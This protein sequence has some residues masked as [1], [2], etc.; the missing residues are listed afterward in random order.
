MAYHIVCLSRP[1]WSL[2][3]Y[4]IE[5]TD[6]PTGLCATIS[7][8]DPMIKSAVIERSDPISGDPADTKAFVDSELK[9]YEFCVHESYYIVRF[10]KICEVFDDLLKMLSRSREEKSARAE[11][12]PPRYIQSEPVVPQP[13]A[14]PAPVHPVP[15]VPRTTDNEIS[16]SKRGPRPLSM[17]F[18][19]GDQI[20]H[21]INKKGKKSER[22][23]T[24]SA[25][26][27]KL[28]LGDDDWPTLGAFVSRHYQSVDLPWSEGANAWKECWYLRIGANGTFVWK[29]CKYL[30]S[31]HQI[32]HDL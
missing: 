9:R 22:I 17:Y 14:P 16:E 26:L 30:K 20:K 15:I 2:N 25:K 12:E 31:P 4:R 29:E 28:V 5:I 13:A 3:V 7:G 23:V 11:G 24:Y 19:D 6:D 18:R 8:T 21:I 27:G 32:A 10:E 1:A